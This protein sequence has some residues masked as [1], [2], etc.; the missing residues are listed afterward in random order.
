MDFIER[1][2]GFSPDH[3]DGSLEAV[4]F[5]V[6]VTIFTGLAVGWFSRQAPFN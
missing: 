4:L 1:Y 6:L 3:G 2:L 5:I